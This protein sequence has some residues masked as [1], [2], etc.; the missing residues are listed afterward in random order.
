MRFSSTFLRIS[1]IFELA[2]IIIFVI[3]GA[4]SVALLVVLKWLIVVLVYGFER[5][6]KRH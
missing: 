1:S 3:K 4:Y 2:A 5:L 6:L